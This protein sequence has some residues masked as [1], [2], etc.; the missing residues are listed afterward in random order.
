MILPLLFG[1]KGDSTG[2]YTKKGITKGANEPN[3]PHA[4]VGRPSPCVPQE[5]QCEWRHVVHIAHQP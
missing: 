1:N 2:G 4:T 3:T 5:R